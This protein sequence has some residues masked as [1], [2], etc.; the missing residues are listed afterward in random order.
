MS[1][2]W[3]EKHRP[4]TFEDVKGQEEAI[5]KIKFFLES[6]NLHKM[7]KKPKKALLLHGPPGVGKTTLALVAAREFNA[8][9][10]ELNASDFRN[11]DKLKDTLKPALQQMSLVNK[12]KVILVD[13]VDGISGTQDRGGIPELISLV[14]SSNF[15]L[16]ITANDAW[17]QKLSSLRSK[18]EMIQLKEM[19][20]KVIREVLMNIIKKENK[21]IEEE[22]ITRISVK[23]NGDIR[24]AINDLQ[25]ISSLVSLDA[26]DAQFDS[27]NKELD[28][29]KALKKVF[30]TKASEETL[31]IY[32][33]VHMP[34]D[35]IMLW[36]E[37]NIPAEY[38]N[39][40]LAIAYDKLS[41]ADVFK[42]RIYKQQYWRFMLYQNIFLSYGIASAKKENRNGFT[43]YKKPT[44]IL[45]IWMNNNK[46][47]HK[48]SISQKYSK[49]VHIGGKRA[50]NEF[51]IIKKIINSSSKIAQELKLTQEE[52]DYLK[53]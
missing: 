29:F 12:T 31:S 49:L 14:E 40:E 33:S 15:P 25:T 4:K 32:D 3:I 22:S 24:A 36:V 10:F 50:M 44:R 27:R 35:E 39:K 52:L 43:K 28:I 20:Y 41:K 48:K 7:T 6:F 8:E 17:S 51:P 5:R 9:I 13:E 46:N 23:A 34:L 11:K 1:Q 21:Y 45:K 30:Q 37:E 16:I 26:K 2:P 42:G 38:R 53:N 47:V 18:T 19:D